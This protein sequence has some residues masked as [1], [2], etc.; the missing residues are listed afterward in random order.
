MTNK[1]KGK[2]SLL[3][4]IPEPNKMRDELKKLNN[5][6]SFYTEYLKIAAKLTRVKYLALKKQGFTEKQ[7]IELSKTL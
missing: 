6:F 3:P 7:A 4:G 2:V 1:T 5:S